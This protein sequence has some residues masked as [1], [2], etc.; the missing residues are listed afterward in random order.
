MEHLCINPLSAELNPIFHLLALLGAHH[1]LHV[2]VLRVNVHRRKPKHL[3]GNC[4]ISTLLVSRI[5]AWDRTQ[6]FAVLGPAI[7]RPSSV[8]AIRRHKLMYIIITR[9]QFTASWTTQSACITKHTCSFCSILY[10]P[11]RQDLFCAFFWVISRRLNFI[12]R[13]FGTLC[14]IFIGL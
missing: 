8:M 3:E 7:E 9:I 14:S 4:P 2:S 1:I 13:R 10:I 11:I 12:C 5:Q 6:S